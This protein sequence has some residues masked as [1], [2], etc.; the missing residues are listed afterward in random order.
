MNGDIGDRVRTVDA[1]PTLLTVDSVAHL[2]DGHTW[3]LTHDVDGQP[4][5]VSGEDV[6][7]V[8]RH[9]DEDPTLT[10]ARLLLAAEDDWL[11]TPISGVLG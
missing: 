7:P 11:A 8:G 4:R 10:P 1:H 2:G 3:L 5:Y 9:T 6:E